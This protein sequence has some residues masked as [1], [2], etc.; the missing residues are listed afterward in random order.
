MLVLREI[1]IIAQTGLSGVVQQADQY[2]TLFR[3][4]SA[5]GLG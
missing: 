5:E 1:D 4:A 2:G 3:P